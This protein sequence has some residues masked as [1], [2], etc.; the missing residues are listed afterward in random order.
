MFGDFVSSL[1]L[2]A[3]SDAIMGVLS[4]PLV[5]A[6][7]LTVIVFYLV[8]FAFRRLYALA[9]SN[10][11]SDEILREFAAAREV[12]S[13]IQ[14]FLLRHPPRSVEEQAAAELGISVE[15]LIAPDP[16]DEYK[17]FSADGGPEMD[18][19]E[20]REILE[21]ERQ[22]GDPRGRVVWLYDET[23]DVGKSIRRQS[24]K[25]R[26]RGGDQRVAE[27][28]GMSVEE[29]RELMAAEEYLYDETSGAAK[30]L[31]RQAEKR[32]KRG[33]DLPF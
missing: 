22:G 6:L 17:V 16:W 18:P 2:S 23:S 19:V 5:P 12:E 8:P 30:S 11:Q 3:L 13:R 9:S 14:S 28:L 24:E 4:I 10:R 21:A 33:G 27:E 32:R 31:R 7:G 25:R 15:E 29:C 1:Q 20:A 26:K